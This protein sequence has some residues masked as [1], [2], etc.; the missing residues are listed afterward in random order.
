MSHKVKKYLYNCE[1][2]KFH[3]DNLTNYKTHLKTKKHNNNYNI[4]AICL[5]QFK[6]A[7]LLK[8]HTI[9]NNCKPI[10]TQSIPINITNNTTNN[11]TNNTT[12]NNTNNNQIYYTL[13][14]N[15]G[16]YTGNRHK[17]VNNLLSE[18]V[19]P[20]TNDETSNLFST[21]LFNLINCD[22]NMLTDIS[23]YKLIKEDFASDVKKEKLN[24]VNKIF[25]KLSAK[26]NLYPN[27]VRTSSYIYKCWLCPDLMTDY[28]KDLAMSECCDWIIH[29]E[30][31]I[32]NY[33][34]TK[35]SE[36]INN[37]FLN[38]N[39]DQIWSLFT[40]RN[41]VYYKDN[42]M[43]L[44]NNEL[45]LLTKEIIISLIDNQEKISNLLFSYLSDYQIKDRVI[46]F[47]YKTILNIVYDKLS[48]FIKDD[49]YHE[50]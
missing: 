38:K 47:E 35:I 37:L 14:L 43:G 32:N 12:N 16:N 26:L 1:K 8:K 20:L 39:N 13:I 11:N 46:N 15:P 40:Q 22:L 18:N 28:E 6:F 27:F 50:Y 23:K 9:K 21:E 19:L 44:N 31:E 42:D 25:I 45:K 36:A 2:C 48:Q 3:N 29:N 10:E 33:L 4:C 24:N 5:K 17:Y 41:R 7:S 34:S 30:S 49:A